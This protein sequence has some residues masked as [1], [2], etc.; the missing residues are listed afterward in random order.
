M[1]NIYKMTFWILTLVIVFSFISNITVANATGFPIITNESAINITETQAMLTANYNSNGFP[2]TVWFRYG[3][4]S[5]L[6]TYLN[7]NPQTSLTGTGSILPIMLSGLLPNTTYYYKVV[8]Q[9]GYGPATTTIN[10]FTT[11]NNNNQN[12]LAPTITT[13]I[14]T[15]ISQNSAVLN[16]NYNSNGTQTNTWFEY[17]TTQSYGQTTS[18]INQGI[19]IGSMSATV[20]GLQVN[21]TYYF[22]AVGQN[23]SGTSYGSQLSFTTLNNQGS[24]LPVVATNNYTSV[25]Q[26]Y[27][28]LNGSVTSTPSVNAW[29]EYGTNCSF[30]QTTSQTS[31]NSGTNN[32]SQYISGLNQNTTYCFRAVAQNNSGT[33]YGSSLQFTT[34]QNNGNISIPSITTNGATLVSQNNASLNAYVNG[35]NGSTNVWFEYGTTMSF[36][37][38][39]SQI[40]YGSQTASPSQYISSL[41]VNT[42]Y[43]FRAVAQNSAGISYGGTMS[44]STN[45][46]YTSAPIVTTNGATNITLTSATLNSYIDSTGNYTTRWFQYGTD[47]LNLSYTTPQIQFGYGTGYANESIYNLQ[48]NTTYYFRIVGQNTYGINYGSVLSFTTSNNQNN[49]NTPTPL[50]TLASLIAEDSAK[51]N[52]LITIN[53]TSSQTIAWFEYGTHVNLGSTTQSQPINSLYITTL[54][55]VQTITGL[56]TNTLYY[57]RLVTQNTYGTT[58][59]GIITFKTLLGSSYDYDVDISDNTNQ[60]ISLR[61]ET[62]DQ[63]VYFGDNV[64]FTISYE[65]ISG[66]ILKNAIIKVIFP[67]EIEFNQSSAEIYSS[68][69]NALIIDLGKIEKEQKGIISIQAKVIDS[70]DSNEKGN[71]SVVTNVVMTY[72]NT[73]NI[74]EDVVA[75]IMN[76]ISR[77]RSLFATSIF[78]D[79]GFLPNTLLGW[80]ILIIV[81]GLLIYVGRLIYMQNTSRENKSTITQTSTSTTQA[82]TEKTNTPN[83]L[84]L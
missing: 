25:G 29:F 18:Q 47:S 9:N 12:N 19:T 79:G 22:R 65:N 36:G 72:V 10:S 33:S 4:D 14:A 44:F 11:S 17:G 5:N 13:N 20:S 23:N 69:E 74:Q 60:K 42:L 61:A 26:T 40:N 34:T 63:N 39:T 7:T 1:K 30:G 82:T 2:T 27:V 68:T 49:T 43:Y 28:T 48:P 76:D 3:T 56:D 77:N 66:T 35:N 58:Y 16:G 31:Y 84:P 83:N 8:A 52:G 71:L 73:N 81:I 62:G 51:L 59:G 37:S 67:R 57:Y 21:T 32:F 80:L 54:N 64:D 75:Y 6:I 41:Q 78:G 15:S 70:N 55:V 24:Q 38:S 46:S 53:N 50:T 45:G